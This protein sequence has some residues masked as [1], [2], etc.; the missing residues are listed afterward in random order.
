MPPAWSPC[1]KD[2]LGATLDGPRLRTTMGHGILHGIYR[3][4]TRQPWTRDLSFHPVGTGSWINLKRAR[5]Y[6]LIT[7][8]PSLPALN[9]AHHGGDYQLT[10]ETLPDPLHE[11]PLVRFVL[12]DDHHNVTR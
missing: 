12:A 6:R 9:I 2:L 4:S 1:D 7:P 3:P 11:V 10:P 5:R 8:G